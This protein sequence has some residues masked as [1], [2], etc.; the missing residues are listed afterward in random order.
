MKR[1]IHT[2][3]MVLCLLVGIG[4]VIFGSYS[5]VKAQEDYKVSETTY[6]GLA[7]IANVTKVEQEVGIT[8]AKPEEDEEEVEKYFDIDFTALKEVN[9]DIVAWIVIEGTEVNYPVLLSEDNAD[10][11]RTTPEGKWATAGSIFLDCASTEDS[12]N[13]IIYGH[14]MKDGSM[15]GVLKEYRSEAFYEEHPYV[16]ILNEEEQVRYQIISVHETRFDSQNYYNTFTESGYEEFLMNEKEISLYP[17]YSQIDTSKKVIT[18]STC[19]NG[20]RSTRLV[21]TLQEG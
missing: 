20:N 19:I 4:G 10:Y 15:F 6:D 17:T 2:I 18:L 3:I 21:L 14:N 13:Y 11:I 8:D 1:V 5:I 7:E 12:I 16:Y 9:E